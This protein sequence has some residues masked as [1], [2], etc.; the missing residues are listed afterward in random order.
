MKGQ[1]F[2]SV[3]KKIARCGI[4][5][6]G[7]IGAKR[8]A[9]LPGGRLI[10]VADRSLA[11]AQKLASA[12]GAAFSS[13]WRDLVKS[14]DIDVVLVCTSHDAL[15][16]IAQAALK[17][18][19]AVFVEKPA[20]KN[21]TQLRALLKTEKST[22]G[23]LRV[24]FNH[25]FH[26]AFLK[27]RRLS[28]TESWGPLL[29]IRARYGHGGRLGY[30]KEWRANPQFSGGGELMDQGVH[31]I[32]LARFLGGEFRLAWGRTKTFFW[33]MPVEDNGFL[34]LESPDGKRNA[35]L[36]ASCTEWKNLFDFEVFYR[37][38]KA[39]VWGLGRSYGQEE[40]RVYRMKPQ[41]GP[42]DL[43]VFPFPDEESSWALEFKAFLK[44]RRGVKTPLAT[45]LD[46][47]KAVDLVH[48]AY[49]QTCS[50]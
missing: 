34:F 7:L 30:E 10:A 36:H 3:N 49:R 12:Y 31:L 35:F 15:T 21:P 45:A 42:P 9:N 4:V 39:Q 24:G 17:A 33:K 47:F 38:V 40:L 19:K 18:G 41:M 13:D 27:L 22:R 25:R 23:F 28:Q 37:S 26:P 5:G 6:A 16:P 43:E 2:L 1:K 50:A 44:E 32:D 8:A 14:P 11:L 29:Y 48:Q 20:G 46:A